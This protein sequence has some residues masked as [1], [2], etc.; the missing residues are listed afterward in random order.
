MTYDVQINI[1]KKYKKGLDKQKY[2][3]CIVFLSNQYENKENKNPIKI[4]D[5]KVTRHETNLMFR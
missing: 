3:D 1:F 4:S 5:K 2:K